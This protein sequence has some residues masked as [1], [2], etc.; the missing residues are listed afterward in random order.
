LKKQVWAEQDKKEADAL[1]AQAAQ[2]AAQ[3]QEQAAQQAAAAAA[4]ITS[5]WQSVTDS[6]FAEVKRIRGLM[7]GNSAQSYSGAQSAFS[8]ATA[9]ARAGDQEAAKLL[10]QLSQTLLSMAEQNAST[11]Q[12]LAYVRAMTANSLEDTAKGNS[13]YGVVLPSFDVGT[14]YVP[15]DMIAQIH[16]GE[17]IIPAAYNN[18]DREARTVSAI[19]ALREEVAQLRAENNAQQ[20]SI[21]QNMDK[22]AKVLTKNDTGSGIWT[23]TTAPA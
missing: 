2:Q 12:D 21:A 11:A 5:A 7:G 22:T 10:P 23:T 3:A 17:A 8:I 19:N 16:E 6:L 18:D 20:I 4:A 15:R 14:N 1:A 13:R 9:Q